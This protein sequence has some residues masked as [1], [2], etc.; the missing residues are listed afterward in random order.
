MSNVLVVTVPVPYGMVVEI[1]SERNG[2]MEFTVSPPEIKGGLPHNHVAFKV[3]PGKDADCVL[4]F[5]P[6]KE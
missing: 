4:R 2:V 3:S 6:E 1:A 5:I